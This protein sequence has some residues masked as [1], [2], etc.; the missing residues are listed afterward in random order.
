MITYAIPSDKGQAIFFQF[1]YFFE[2]KTYF[3]F[4]LVYYFLIK[5]ITQNNK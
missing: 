3:E 5:I 1:L 2:N 4:K